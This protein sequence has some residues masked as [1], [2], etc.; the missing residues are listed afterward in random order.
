VLYLSN[1]MLATTSPRENLSE[2]KVSIVCEA[3]FPAEIRL[4]GWLD[5]KILEVDFTKNFAGANRNSTKVE[6]AQN[7]R[8]S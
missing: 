4:S 8:G 7:S 1:S 3:F 6:P 2:V 5:V